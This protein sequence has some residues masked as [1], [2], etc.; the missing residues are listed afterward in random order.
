MLQPRP[1]PQ[2]GTTPPE[3]QLGLLPPEDV[4]TAASA[5]ATAAAGLPSSDV[6]LK[7]GALCITSAVTAA[8]RGAEMAVTEDEYDVVQT[9]VD[10]SDR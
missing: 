5:A 1:K 6:S 3:F 7:V 8:V 9:A 4:A 10:N 2:F